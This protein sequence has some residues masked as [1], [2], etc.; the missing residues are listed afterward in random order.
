MNA[1]MRRVVFQRLN[2]IVSGKEFSLRQSW[3]ES[4]PTSNFFA[5]ITQTHTRKRTLKGH[6][7]DRRAFGPKNLISFIFSISKI[8]FNVL[9]DNLHRFD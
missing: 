2:S 7:I 5:K 1:V 9:D 4:K 6:T 3:D 8:G